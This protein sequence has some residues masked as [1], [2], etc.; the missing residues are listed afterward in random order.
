MLL[1]QKEQEVQQWRIEQQHLLQVYQKEV[2]VDLP[3]PEAAVLV[4]TVHIPGK[5]K[6]VRKNIRED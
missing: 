2:V 6:Q 3:Q 4:Q 5:R 1:C